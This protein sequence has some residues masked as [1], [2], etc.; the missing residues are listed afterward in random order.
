MPER[1]LWAALGL[2]TVLSLVVS[3]AI[4]AQILTLGHREDGWLYGYVQPFSTRALGAVLLVGGTVSGLLLV[5]R[6][7]SPQRDWLTLIVWIV[8]ATGLHAVLR[9]LTPWSLE[10]IFLSDTA[11][12]FYGVIQQF[13]ARNVLDEFTRVRAR[14]PLHA[15]SNMPGKLMFVYGL[16]AISPRTDVLPWLIVIVSNLG[17][18]PMYW[19]ALSVADDRR[20]ARYAAILYLFVPARLL[21]FPLL[22][23]ITPVFVLCCAWLLMR[24]LRRG[25]ASDAMMLGILLYGLVFFEPLPLV[26]G[27]LFAALIGRAIWQGE[28]SPKP[29]FAQIGLGAVGFAVTY[30]AMFLWFGFELIEALQAVG[31]H[32][33]EFNMQARRP[34]DVWIWRNVIEF[35]FGV[36]ICQ[37]VLFWAGLADGIRTEGRWHD[38]L[39]QPLVVVSLGLL[40]VLIAT[41]LIGINRAEVARL[42][43]FL[44]C[45]FQVPAAYVCAR[46]QSDAA[47]LVVLVTSALQAGL[48]TALM[49]FVVLP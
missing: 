16:Q 21:F 24:W 26:I 29:V 8:A 37:V 20:L 43:I 25:A 4:A 27:L 38:R 46:L 30:L 17:A 9:S 36:G 11:N 42:W 33:E 35:A 40:A 39:A 49:G 48:A 12:S 15:L 18:L 19:F 44:A 10:Q 22:N 2:G 31:A 45:F 28:R 5:L 13:D 32:A 41:D 3:A 6:P 14:W 1:R 7:V 23:T 34:Y 47:L